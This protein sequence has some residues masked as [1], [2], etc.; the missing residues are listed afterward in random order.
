MHDELR[1]RNQVIANGTERT[2]GRRDNVLALT[3]AAPKM[4]QLADELLQPVR[5]HLRASRHADS[6]RED[7]GDRDEARTDGARSHP[8]RRGGCEMTSSTGSRWQSTFAAAGGGGARRAG[9]ADPQRRRAR[10][11]ERHR[12]RRASKYVTD[13]NEE[14]F[15]VFEDGAKQKLTSSRRRSS[16]S[17][18]RC[19]S[20]PARAWTSAW[21]SPRKRRSASPGSCTRTIRPRS[22]T[23]TA[24]SAS[25]RRS[26]TTPPRSRRRSARRR[27]N[28]ST[29]LYNAIY[30]S[31]K[32]LKK[33]QGGDRPPRSA[34]RRSSLLS[35][36][37]DTSSLIEFDEVLDLAKR[38]ETAIY[39]IGL[40]QAE[41]RPAR[42][43]GS[44]VRAASSWRSETGG[45]AFFPTDARELAKIYQQI[46][47]RARQPVRASPTRRGTRSAT[48]PG[49]A[50]VVRRRPARA[51]R[52]GPS[53]VLRPDQR[54]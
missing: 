50:S 19:C 4:K 28:G 34:A 18:W 5:R 24:R 17:R 9:T 54:S 33:V 20:T 7:R 10:V 30:I 26:P 23:S 14:E 6:T 29:S 36:G 49:G 51:P 16:R 11:A 38:S 53:R 43:Q 32:E 25:S 52:R 12:H 44:G 47:G 45:R 1:N 22:S 31:L 27:A 13:L 37:D 15:E 41:T 21:R 39:A 46:C 42:V 35:D 3:A 2:G 8:D 48:A 40:R